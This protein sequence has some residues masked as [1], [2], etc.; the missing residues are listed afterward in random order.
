MKG[1]NTMLALAYLFLASGYL[2]LAIQHLGL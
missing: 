1:G 2:L